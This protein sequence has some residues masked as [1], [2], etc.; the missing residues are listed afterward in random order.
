[1][2]ALSIILVTFLLSSYTFAQN[3]NYKVFPFKTGIIEYKQEGNAKGTHVK[4]IDEYGYKQADFSETEVKVF[5]FT[6]KENKGT[7]LI[8]PKLYSLDYKTNTASTTKNPV[9][10]SYANSN[11]S[12]YDKLGRDAM[13]SLGFSNT[14]KTETIAGKKCEIWKG[15]LGSIWVW[16]SLAL[17]SETNILGINIIEVATSVKINISVPSSKF[18]VPNRMEVKEIDIPN[19]QTNYGNI[20]DGY[21]SS[22]D[23]M[24]NEEKQMMQ[25]AMDGNM[26]GVMSAAGSQM[27]KEEKDQIKKISNMSYPEFKR[28]VQKEEPTTTEE[29]IKQA[30]EMTKQMAKYIK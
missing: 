18:E 27:S 30:Y 25:D 15:S 2:K 11:G 6:N 10:E 23:D 21:E 12:D 24:T 3:S 8:G 26:E 14:G 9:Y 20:N 17:K 1:M 5:G 7:I 29:E 13:A 4:Y 28:M 19:N 22:N 16:K